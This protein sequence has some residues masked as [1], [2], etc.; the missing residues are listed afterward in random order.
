MGLK[1]AGNVDIE[2]KKKLK[3]FDFSKF[4]KTDSL[5][6]YVLILIAT[7]FLFYLI[8][9]IQ[10]NMIIDWGGDY[11]AQYF[12]MGYHS[13]DTWR[14]IFAGKFNFWDTTIYLGVNSIAS[15]SYYGLFSPY[16]LFL[17]IFPREWI[18][19]TLSILSIIKLV[20][21]GLF[22][23]CYM[24]S[25]GVK[26]STAR[27]AGLA[28]AFSGYMCFYLWYNNYQDVFSF[29]P[30]ILLGIEL[31]LQKKRPWVLMIGVTL[32]I[33]SNFVMA[34][35]FL[36][37]GVIYG[38]F[39]YFQR[40]KL[41]DGKTNLKIL[42]IGFIGFFLGITISSAI[43]IPS[44][45]S[46]LSSPKME[47]STYLKLLK[48]APD[49]IT[50]I[51][52][53]FDWSIVPD[54]HGYIHSWR[55]VGPILE[56]FFP[57]A[58]C[59]TF[60]LLEYA[61][62]GWDFDDI[63]TSFWVFT[64]SLLFL[65]PAII[66]SIKG[67]KVSHIIAICLFALAIFTP[68]CYFAL[69]G[70]SNGYG[71]WSLFFTTSVLA[72][73][74]VYIDKIPNVPK[75]NLNFGL[76][77]ALIGIAMTWIIS[78]SLIGT[79][80]NGGTIDYRFIYNDFNFFV[81]AMIVETVYVIGV[82]LLAFL[83]YNKKSFKKVMIGFVMLEAAVCGALM[84]FGQGYCQF[85]SIYNNHTI[86]LNNSLRSC[87]NKI[88]MDDK[89]YYRSFSSLNDSYSDNNGMMNG[90]NGLSYFHSL[91]NFYVD[92]FTKSTA[93]RSDSAAVGGRYLGKYQDLDNILGVKY[94]YIEKSKTKY[95]EIKEH[96]PTNATSNVPFNYELVEE[97][98]NDDFLIYKNTAYQELGYCYSNYTTEKLRTNGGGS[99]IG[100]SVVKQAIRF[101]QFVYIPEADEERIEK[102][103]EGDINITTPYGGNLTYGTLQF[104]ETPQPSV[105]PYKMDYYRLP[106]DSE[107]Y[108]TCFH[109][110]KHL[111]NVKNIPNGYGTIIEK[112]HGE[113]TN[114]R[115]WMYIHNV[116]NEYLFD[117]DSVAIYI[118]M[119]FSN[120]Y[121]FNYYF[122]DENNN[123]FMYDDH[124][125]YSTNNPNPVRGFYINQKV[126]GILIR[127][128]YS[129]YEVGNDIFRYETK[130]SYDVRMN[131]LLK[132][133]LKNVNYKSTSEVSFETDFDKHKLVVTRYTYD[134]GWKV[135]SIN[136]DGSKEQ[137]STYLS[138]GG[139]VGFVSK[140]GNAKYIMYYETPYINVSKFLTIF[141]I[142]L[143]FATYIGCM[144]FASKKKEKEL[145]TLR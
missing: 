100:Y 65:V 34:V 66:E 125:N 127:P 76:A 57:P 59:R 39:R 91:Y 132:Y 115:V 2:P 126:K 98:S 130:Q 106:E 81:I 112:P 21:A 101:E 88:D 14:D 129:L 62:G 41:F 30:L 124:N 67:K 103:G 38:L 6:F 55:Q 82:W 90:Y 102:E 140:K 11:T 26:E 71:R 56:F 145:F 40:L 45:V 5:L 92:D 134:P 24:K 78:T 122:L 96:N 25:L 37:C 69:M 54:Q 20:C 138:Q 13:Y 89:T 108:D 120:S 116:N 117:V 47:S 60:N 53:I 109:P 51:R 107:G 83:L 1:F 46:A 143:G 31:I 61:N 131:N 133:K 4:F 70:F 87:I 79:K 121:H 8:L 17:I 12:V 19:W 3:S 15:N 73:T 10:N 28:Y 68:F 97:Y 32:C 118:S 27:I 94:Y 9:L 75:M 50:F 114:D 135:F 64:P 137:L 49:F 18:P 105:S 23:R 74:F 36:I 95:N 136:E 35:T 113:I 52:Y 111:N 84:V 80:A 119:W 139:F 29:F 110:E 93:L 72:Y 42:G 104:Y 16:N 33:V 141:S 43:F 58:T 7:A 144:Y 22:F 77:F 123:V 128:D 85:D 44:F 63:C 99:D 48:T 86:P 142:T